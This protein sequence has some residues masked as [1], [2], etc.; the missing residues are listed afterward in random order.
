L[1]SESAVHV[2]GIKR[3]ITQAFVEGE[4]AWATGGRSWYWQPATGDDVYE[5]KVD[6]K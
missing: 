5:K 2:Y 1:K 3:T 4:D 6:G